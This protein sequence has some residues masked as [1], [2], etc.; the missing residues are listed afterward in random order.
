MSLFIRKLLHVQYLYSCRISKLDSQEEQGRQLEAAIEDLC[1][2][3]KE[4]QTEAVEVQSEIELALGYLKEKEYEYEDILLREDEAKKQL[5]RAKTAPTNILVAIDSINRQKDELFVSIEDKQ[6]QM[7]ELLLEFSRA[8]EEVRKR[9]DLK[10][11]LR[12]ELE[13]LEARGSERHDEFNDMER[14]VNQGLLEQGSYE[15]DFILVDKQI[16][17][18]TEDVKKELEQLDK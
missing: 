16:K 7:E 11:S 18:L 15:S 4:R 17:E 5:I 10:Q 12:H 1:V 3:I 8:K 2:D 6:T 13:Q 9:E 14:G